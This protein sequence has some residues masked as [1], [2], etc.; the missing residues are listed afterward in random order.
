LSRGADWVEG[1]ERDNKNQVMLK[2]KWLK[3]RV[4]EKVQ[5]LTEGPEKEL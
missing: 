2:N 3:I 4:M 1:V 5:L